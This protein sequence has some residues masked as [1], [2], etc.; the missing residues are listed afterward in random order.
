[1]PL[2]EARTGREFTSGDDVY[3]RRPRREPPT[4]N[5]DDSLVRPV[6]E[7]MAPVPINVET[8]LDRETRFCEGGLRVTH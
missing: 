6:R 4:S 8:L 5:R 7:G 2:R 3:Q 1:M